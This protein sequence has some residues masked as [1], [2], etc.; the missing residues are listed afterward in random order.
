MSTLP[1]GKLS[2]KLLAQLLGTQTLPDEVLLGPQPGEDGCAIALGNGVLVAATDPITLV[3]SDIGKFAVY[4]NANDIAVMGVSPRWF[5]A[6]VLLPPGTTSGD[7]ERLF[8]ALREALAHVGG[9]LVGG[10][11]EVTSAVRQPVVV[12]QMLGYSP[13]G[14]F[15]RTGGLEVGHSVL[16]VGQAPVE[17]AAVLAGRASAEHTSPEG[18]DPET[19]AAARA[20]VERPGILVVEPALIAAEHGAS[21]LHD[22]T[23]GG[24]ATGLW[25]MAETSGVRL[26]IASKKVQWFSAGRRLCEHYGLDPWGTLASGCLLVGVRPVNERALTETLQHTGYRVSVLATA[27]PGSGV[28]IDGTLAPRFERDEL[29][30]LD[31]AP[32]ENARSADSAPFEH[33]T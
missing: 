13:S 12:G 11:T 2:S 28:Y 8:D 9:T 19:L 23:E 26:D 27:T 29:S 6:S 32:P 33:G 15:V 20:A 3:G 5:L 22:P 21:A 24:L 17:G 16:Q 14:H 7:A 10:H 4:I 25:E 31:D 30:R 1:P 18:I